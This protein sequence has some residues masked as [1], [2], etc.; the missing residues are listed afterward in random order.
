MP[1]IP[2]SGVVP[3]RERE[4]GRHL[5]YVCLCPFVADWW[6]RIGRADAAAS[7]VLLRLCFQG[8]EVTSH[9]MN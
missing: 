6:N 9:A 2:I 3:P 4:E 1:N 7:C 5:I 8:A